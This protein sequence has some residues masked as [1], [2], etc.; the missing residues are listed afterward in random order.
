MRSRSDI[1]PPDFGEAVDAARRA[2]AEFSRR[3][4]LTRPPVPIDRIAGM[5]GYRIVRLHDVPDEFS[6]MVSP[7]EALIGVNGRHH[8]HR[9]RFTIGHEIGHVLLC[10]PPEARCTAVRARL[11]NLEADRCASELLMPARLLVPL[12]EEGWEPAAL[13]RLFGVS[14]EA[15]EVR[16]KEL[17]RRPR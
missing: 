6:G 8:E 4:G 7:R 2:L 16:L 1:S 14:V 13:A 5:L 17:G 15:L 9:R 10:H 3:E 12:L 11:H